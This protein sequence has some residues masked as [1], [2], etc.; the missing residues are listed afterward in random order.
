MSSYLKS[1]KFQAAKKVAEEKRVKTPFKTRFGWKALFGRKDIDYSFFS[2][3]NQ[4][5]STIEIPH[6][7]GVFTASRD[8]VVSFLISQRYAD[9]KE[10]HYIKEIFSEVLGNA[11]TEAVDIEGILRSQLGPLDVMLASG[12]DLS[13][14][15]YNSF[16]EI[17]RLPAFPPVGQVQYVRDLIKTPDLQ[18]NCNLDLIITLA[19]AVLL[20]NLK[21][22]MEVNLMTLLMS[23]V[24]AGNCTSEFVDRKR[25]LVRKMGFDNVNLGVLPTTEVISTIWKFL[26][27]Y[28]KN[29]HLTPEAFCQNIAT[30][31]RSCY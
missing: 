5:V 6:V 19:S 2:V 9:N 12:M 14:E 27:Y 21:L 18:A 24:K 29:D 11:T 20:G 1:R 7:K 16:Q 30:L 4:Y 10:A 26:E 28:I 15:D 25:A 22:D 23:F 13:D 17:V 31:S 3:R 8:S